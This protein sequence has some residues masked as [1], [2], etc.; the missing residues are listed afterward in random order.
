MADLLLELERELRARELWADEPPVAEHLASTTP[1]AADRLAIEEW[2]QWIFVP[3]IKQMIEA[4][5]ELPE[6]CNIHPYAE[7]CLKEMSEPDR[8]LAILSK[9]DR[10]ITSA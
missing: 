7:E 1:F 10:H 4:G 6:V 5:A 3:T 9:I 2:L 8:L